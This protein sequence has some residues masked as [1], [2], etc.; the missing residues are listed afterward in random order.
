M[1]NFDEI[2]PSNF[3]LYIDTNNLYGWA[4][5]HYLPNGNFQ[6]LKNEDVIKDTRQIQNFKANSDIC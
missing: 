6:W 4:I 3:L 2:S 5:R 1:K